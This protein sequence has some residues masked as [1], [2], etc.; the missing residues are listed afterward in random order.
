MEAL[1]EDRK[2]LI[3]LCTLL[4]TTRFSSNAFDEPYTP[5]PMTLVTFSSN[6]P[7]SNREDLNRVQQH[8]FWLDVK[9][10]KLLLLFQT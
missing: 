3:R 10:Q 2:D 7:V 6:D 8:G 5:Q 4:K 1:Q 9:R